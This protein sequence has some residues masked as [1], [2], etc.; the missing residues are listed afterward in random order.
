MIEVYGTMTLAEGS[1][2]SRAVQWPGGVGFI[3]VRG[4][5]VTGIAG[6]RLPEFLCDQVSFTNTELAAMFPVIDFIAD[7]VYQFEA[8]AGTIRFYAGCSS[9][10][11]SLNLSSPLLIVG[12]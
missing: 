7:G 3:L 5:T 2:C 10:G 1:D 12:P 9:P 11:D 6:I 4:L 8:P